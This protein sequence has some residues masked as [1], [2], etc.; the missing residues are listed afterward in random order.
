MLNDNE[1]A[2]GT[3]LDLREVSLA[4]LIESALEPCRAATPDALLT[5]NSFH[6]FPPMLLDARRFSSALRELLQWAMADSAPGSTIDLLLAGSNERAELAISWRRDDEALSAGTPPGPGKT[7]EAHGGS[8]SLDAGAGS[9]RLTLLLPV[10]RP[11]MQADGLDTGPHERD[12]ASH[13]RILLAEDSAIDRK[14]TATLLERKG[15]SVTRVTGGSEAVN[16][17]LMGSFDIVLMDLR[18]P[19]MDGYAAAET[20]R[21]L[22]SGRGQRVPIIALSIE[23]FQDS[24]QKCLDAGMDGMLS[25]PFR[26]AEFELLVKQLSLEATE[27]RRKE[28]RDENPL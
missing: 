5:F 17:F 26:S 18:M 13:L 10:L 3:P 23:D 2:G 28:T 25:K 8:V 19:G 24:L 14:L 11:A 27:A 22:D 7:I 6:R 9:C 4:R 20:I 12:A 1:K 15:H 16:A 21:R